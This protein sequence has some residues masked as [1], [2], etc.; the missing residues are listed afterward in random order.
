MHEA[1]GSQRTEDYADAM[2]RACQALNIRLTPLLSAPGVNALLNRAVT[3]AAREFPFLKHVGAI[4]APDCSLNGLRQAL[5]EHDPSEAAD[6]LVAI[7]A[8][9]LWLL[10][11]FIGEN[12]GL[13]KVHEAWPDVPFKPPELR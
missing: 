7:L 11:D 8:N 13:R 2:E 5:D 12:L 3:L 10:V 6:A 9:F 4:T 1:G